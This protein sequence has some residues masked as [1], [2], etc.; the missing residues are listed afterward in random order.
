MRFSYKMIKFTFFN[1]GI[2][3]ERGWGKYDIY[4]KYIM[5]M[6]ITFGIVFYNTNR[7]L[8]VRIKFL[9]FSFIIR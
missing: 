8:V 5:E 4:G 9:E 1:G 7:K 2:S 6:Y 3:R